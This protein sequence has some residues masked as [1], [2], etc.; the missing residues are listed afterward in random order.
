MPEST[1]INFLRYLK[2]QCKDIE[3]AWIRNEIDKFLR[4]YESEKV[5][6]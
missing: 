1:I 2:I 6:T 3:L 5:K 4:E